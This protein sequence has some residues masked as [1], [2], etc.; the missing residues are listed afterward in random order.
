[1]LQNK[2]QASSRFAAFTVQTQ[3]AAGHAHSVAQSST[4]LTLV[5]PSWSTAR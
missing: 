5:L 3:P 4:V 1:M 2:K